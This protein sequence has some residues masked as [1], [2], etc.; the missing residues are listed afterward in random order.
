MVARK[1]APTVLRFVGG[2]LR[3]TDQTQGPPDKNVISFWRT[4][5]N[6]KVHKSKRY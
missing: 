6:L 1:R 2:R 4:R 5:A 3:A